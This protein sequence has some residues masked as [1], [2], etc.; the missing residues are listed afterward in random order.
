ME[1]ADFLTCIHSE[2]YVTP[3]IETQSQI[4]SPLKQKDVF[5]LTYIGFI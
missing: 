1:G 3:K 4:Q 5:L 2:V